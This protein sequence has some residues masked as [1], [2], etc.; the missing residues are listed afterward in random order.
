MPVIETLNILTINCNIIGTQE[1]K[2]PNAVQ[3]QP[4]A[5]MQDVSNTMQTQS[6]L[7][8]GWEAVIQTEAAIQI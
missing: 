6:R 1:T 4:I 8:A 2:P 3:M 5:R 7:S